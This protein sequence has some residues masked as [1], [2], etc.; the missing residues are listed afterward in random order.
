VNEPETVWQQASELHWFVPPFSILDIP[1]P[2]NEDSL[3]RSRK[4]FVPVSL[5][6]VVVP[7]D[8]VVSWDFEPIKTA[9]AQK[10]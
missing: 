4:V 5:V 6:G 3:S 1:M 2:A 9:D 10:H 7:V 8:R